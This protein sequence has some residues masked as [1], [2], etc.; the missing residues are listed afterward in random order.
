MRSVVGAPRPIRSIEERLAA[1]EEVF[2]QQIGFYEGDLR[3]PEFVYRCF[4]EF[5]PEAIVHLGEQP[6]P[7]TA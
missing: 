3:D 2:G 1:F 4:E 6:Q 7:R 5:Q